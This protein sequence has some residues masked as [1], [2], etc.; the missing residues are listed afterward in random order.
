MKKLSILVV[1][2]GQNQREM[3]RDFLRKE[4]HTVGEAENGEQAV[5]RVR[6]ATTTCFSSTT[7][8][9]GWTG[10]RSSRR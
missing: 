2:D 9:P 1:E 7:K 10:C 6:R 3:L 4:G 5:R 8:C